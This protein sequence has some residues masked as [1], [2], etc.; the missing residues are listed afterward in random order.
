MGQEICE[1]TVNTGQLQFLSA[2]CARA[3]FAKVADAQYE[4][5]KRRM[6][7]VIDSVTKSAPAD[8]R[9]PWPLGNRR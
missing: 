6:Q 5:N 1:V 2:P 8:S 4:A 7:E 3:E 9:Q